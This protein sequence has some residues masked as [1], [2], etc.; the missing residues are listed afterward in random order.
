MMNH[1]PINF[2]LK[3]VGDGVL[4]DEL[5]TKISDLKLASRVKMVGMITNVLEVISECHIF[6]L[7]SYIEGFP[8]VVIESLSV[9]TPVISFEVGGVSEII[10][11]GFNGY[12]IKRDDTAG[13]LNKILTAAGKTW[14]RES[15]RGDIF[16]RFGLEKVAARYEELIGIK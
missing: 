5:L 12:V 8:N 6:V 14:N 1:L 15:I 9:G 11:D 7:P 13:F 3:I 10:R 2:T 16:E 4:K